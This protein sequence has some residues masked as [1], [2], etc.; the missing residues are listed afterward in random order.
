[1]TKSSTI[2]EEF[3]NKKIEVPT[4]SK[5]LIFALP[6]CSVCSW[7]W[8]CLLELLISAETDLTWTSSCLKETFLVSWTVSDPLEK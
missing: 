1:M 6:C 4:E 2:G 7:T 8:L 3:D 5:M